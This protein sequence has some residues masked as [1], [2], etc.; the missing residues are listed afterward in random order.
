MVIT[1]GEGAAFLT[2]Y[3]II[4][5]DLLWLINF[6]LD[7]ALLWGTA[8]FGGFMAGWWRLGLAA[9]AGACYGVGLLFPALA[10]LYALPGPLLFSLL[11]LFIAFGRLPW[12]RWGW[13]VACFYFLSFVMGGAALAGAALL[14]HSPWGGRIH[15]YDLLPAVLAAVVLGRLGLAGFRRLLRSLGLKATLEL[16]LGEGRAHLSCFFDTGNTLREPAYSAAAGGRPVLLAELAALKPLLPPVLWADLR[17]LYRREGPSAR[18]YQLLQRY[19]SLP[20]LSGRLLLLPY[21]SVGQSR[22]LLLGF[23]PDKSRFLLPDGRVIEHGSD[24]VVGVCPLP[25]AGLKGCQALVN[26]EA[27]FALNNNQENAAA[28]SEPPFP[29]RELAPA[30]PGS[31]DSE[32]SEQSE[33]SEHSELQSWPLPPE[34][35]AYLAA[36]GD[37]AEGDLRLPALFDYNLNNDTINNNT[38]GRISA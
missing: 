14:R 35:L 19:A 32:H 25:L 22:G 34:A 13:L 11:L 23:A 20:G 5:A 33:Q 28:N 27:V 17:E 38:K 9:A 12:R 21:A 7:L 26:P 15:I 6:L 8:R 2:S 1:K 37:G 18:P 3:Y 16:S 29:R 31:I 24:L 36:Y 4:Y 10:P 30:N